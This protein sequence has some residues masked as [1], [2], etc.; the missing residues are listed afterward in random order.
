MHQ[1][2]T[3]NDAIHQVNNCC[4]S[5]NDNGQHS[6]LD[7]LPEENIVGL[8]KRSDLAMRSFRKMRGVNQQPSSPAVVQWTQRRQSPEVR[9]GVDKPT[10]RG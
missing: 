8:D 3:S 7:S 2:R 5:A 9:E 6:P 10:S 4:D 1:Y